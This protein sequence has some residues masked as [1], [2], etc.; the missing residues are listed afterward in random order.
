MKSAALHVEACFRVCNC[1]SVFP[2][3]SYSRTEESIRCSYSYGSY[4][5]SHSINHRGS[6]C[7]SSPSTVSVCAFVSPT[8]PAVPG[9]RRYLL[10]AHVVKVLIRSSF[11]LSSQTRPFRFDL[12][13]PHVTLCIQ[14]ARGSAETLIQAVY[15]L[16]LLVLLSPL[17]GLS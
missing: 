16:N 11:V 8:S 13:I 1:T 3:I 12:S 2:P 6:S 17:A 4:S 7:I 10:S 5:W 14:F 9:I 15:F